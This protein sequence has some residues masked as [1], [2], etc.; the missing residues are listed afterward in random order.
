MEKRGDMRIAEK[1]KAVALKATTR[2]TLRADRE[3]NSRPS[4]PSSGMPDERVQR[5]AV[6]ARAF[7]AEA[8]RGDDPFTDAPPDRLRGNAYLFCHLGD[9]VAGAHY[10]ISHTTRPTRQAFCRACR[11]IVILTCHGKTR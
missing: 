7:R 10:R 8:L 5:F 9:A 4:K 6:D 1:L 11:K 3:V 2:C